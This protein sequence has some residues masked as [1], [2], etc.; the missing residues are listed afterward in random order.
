MRL[1]IGHTELVGVSVGQELSVKS[2]AKRCAK[3]ELTV[4]WKLV[5]ELPKNHFLMSQYLL[6]NVGRF[7]DRTIKLGKAAVLRFRK[8]ALKGYGSHRRLL[9][10][11]GDFD[12]G[13][14]IVQ[15]LQNEILYL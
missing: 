10:E 7:T 5:G 1:K 12:D 11:S 3:R 15:R 14:E 2:F 8:Y 9:Y 6:I 13:I 4:D